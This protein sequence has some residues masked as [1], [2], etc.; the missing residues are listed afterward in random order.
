MGASAE[1]WISRHPAGNEAAAA[2]ILRQEIEEKAQSLRAL[3][4]GKTNALFI[5]VA[6]SPTSTGVLV[7]RMECMI[8]R[9]E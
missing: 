2:L 1:T 9:I 4:L 5:I 3:T 8:Y 7:R 6:L